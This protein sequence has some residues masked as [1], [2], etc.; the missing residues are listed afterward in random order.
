AAE[1]RLRAQRQHDDGPGAAVHHGAA[2]QPGRERGGQPARAAAEGGEVEPRDPRRAVP[3]EAVP[4]AERGGAVGAG[5]ARR[6]GGG[7]A[8]G[9][10]GRAVGAAELE[11]VLAAE[12]A[13]S[14]SWMRMSR[15][16]NSAS[17]ICTPLR[18]PRGMR[19]RRRPW[20]MTA[21]I[22]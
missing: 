16:S 17:L 15:N 22:A 18:A 21:W 19:A 13:P 1:L 5:G 10:G 2:R 6:A 11:G 4:A 7:P 8:R 14:F 9:A 3:G 12:V 20:M